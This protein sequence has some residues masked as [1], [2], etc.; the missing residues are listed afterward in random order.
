MNAWL[1]IDGFPATEIAAHT[2]PTW[3]T[4]AD[5]GCGEASF[6]LALSPR[7]QHPAL[8]ARSLVEILVGQVPVYVGELT[9]PDRTTWECHA[10]GLST[11]LRR[12]LALDGLGATTRDVGAALNRAMAVGWPG[13]NPAPITGVAAGDADGNPVTVGTL[14][15]D[16]ASQTGQRWGVDEFRRVYMS[17][18]AVT[19]TWLAAPDA[20]AFG[21]TNEDAPTMLAGRYDTGAGFATA[22][23]GVPGLEESVDLTDRGILTE[24]AAEA[25][26]SGLLVR[27]GDAQWTNGATLHREQL[28]TTGGTP[29][30]LPCVRARQVMRAHGLGYN[31]T[32][33][34]P[35]LDVTIGKTTYTAGE[36]TIY[37]EPV[38]TAPRN[39][40]DVIAAA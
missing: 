20:T 11:G 26:L 31:I 3:A 9:E 36:D 1:R 17:P 18:E 21:T 25:I 6:A 39:L 4:L 27:R 34:A 23:A 7:A 14:L 24:V 2:A 29:A 38:N 13:V 35:W 5:G 16:Y 22:F 37:V 28:T 30:F 10:T 19:P 12:I 33:Q 8:T 40:T 32:S 15:D